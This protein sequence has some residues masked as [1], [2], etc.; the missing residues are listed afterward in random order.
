MILIA[1]PLRS[2]VLAVS[3]CFAT[4]SAPDHSTLALRKPAEVEAG[5]VTLKVAL[6]LAPGRAVNALALGRLAA[7]RKAWPEALGWFVRAK[8]LEPHYWEA[9]LWIARCQA[10][11]GE[12]KKAI[13][14][15][16]QIPLE[17]AEVRARIDARRSIDRYDPSGYERMILSYDARVVERE[18]LVGDVVGL[19]RLGEYSRPWGAIRWRTA[20]GRGW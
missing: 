12:R 3:D 9:S 18:L 10:A 20:S 1:G 8:T 17:R 5:D 2:R 15:L 14:T 19:R 7:R 11:L 6:T 4:P 16:R 13:F